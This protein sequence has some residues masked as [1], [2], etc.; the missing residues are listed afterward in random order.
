MIG[1]PTDLS[2]LFLQ[3]KAQVDAE[4]YSDGDRALV[5]MLV[6]TA[7]AKSAILQ[8]THGAKNIGGETRCPCCGAGLRF[9]VQ[10]NGH[11]WAHCATADCVS[12]LE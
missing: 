6:R 10:W 5:L 8:A 9:T 3:T 4:P 1:E 11:V 12:F 7:I 2:A